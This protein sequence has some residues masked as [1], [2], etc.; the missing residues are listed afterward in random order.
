MNWKGGTGKTSTA[1]ALI[2]GLR[3]EGKKVLAVDADP[4]GNLTNMMGGDSSGAARG[5]Y[6]TIVRGRS[7]R[8]SIQDTPQGPVVAADSRLAEK[9]I[10]IGRNTEYRIR[11]ALANVANDYDVTVIDCAPGLSTLNYAALTAADGI[12]IP[13]K[14][15]RFCVDALA[16]IASTINA[17]KSNSNRRLQVYGVLITMY[18]RRLTVARLMRE[19]VEEQA[20]ALGLPVYATPIRKCVAIEESEVT[21]EDIF[22]AG[23]NN[24]A[25]DYGEIIKELLNQMD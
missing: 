17:V 16:Q 11:E 7:I 15:D 9:G 2:A 13:C 19:K 6:D 1:A 12:V 20:A 23:T 25:T 24:A 5:L 21:G 18:E 10:L 22:T 3:R 4:Q 8:N 14:A